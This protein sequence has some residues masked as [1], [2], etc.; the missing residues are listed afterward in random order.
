[1]ISSENDD[2]SGEAHLQGEKEAN[3]LAALLASVDI[4]SK[5]EIPGVFGDDKVTLL[6]FV[7]IA[8]L[9]KHVNE[10]RILSMDVSKYFD[11][12]LKLHE[13]LLVLEYLLYLF[14]QELN[15]FIWEVNEWYTLWV[16]CF[17]SDDVVVQVVNYYIHDKDHLVVKIL[18]WNVGNPFFECFTPFFLDV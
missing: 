13:W 5:E 11:W 14:N 8:H 18:L 2:L 10:I 16:L 4:V 9:L 6:C 15:H 3:N 7:L 1:M 12:S 17:V